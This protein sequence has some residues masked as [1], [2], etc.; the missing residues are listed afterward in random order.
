M[1]LSI[2]IWIFTRETSY[3]AEGEARKR[4]GVSRPVANKIGAIDR[5]G[6]RNRKRCSLFQCYCRDGT[7]VNRLLTIAGITG[8]RVGDPC[9][10]VPEL[11]N[12]G[13]Q[14]RAKSA[15]DA[16]VHINYRGSHRYL[17]PFVIDQYITG[18]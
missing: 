2:L 8:I 18:C 16:E 9:L 10:I 11:E 12:L 7:A 6:M 4:A 14:F 13:A 17:H 15:T 3:D 1:A 5:P